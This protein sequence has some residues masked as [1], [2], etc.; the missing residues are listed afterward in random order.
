MYIPFYLWITSNQAGN[1]GLEAAF[2]A[3]DDTHISIT[4]QSYSHTVPISGK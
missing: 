4:L 3:M 2:V 1:S